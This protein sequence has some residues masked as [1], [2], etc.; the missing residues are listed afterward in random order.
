MRHFRI[1][2][3]LIM[4]CLALA[5]CGGGGGGG[6][7]VE[8]RVVDGYVAG[9][10]VYLVPVGE[11]TPANAIRHSRPTDNSGQ[12]KIKMP[13]KVF[14]NDYASYHLIAV[15]GTDT[16]TSTAAPTYTSPINSTV[17]TPLTTLLDQLAVGISSNSQSG[18]TSSAVAQAA[19]QIATVA[20][21]DQSSALNTIL[22]TDY[23]D[24]A[25][26]DANAQKALTM[27]FIIAELSAQGVIDG[28]FEGTVSKL[29]TAL[30]RT[31]PPTTINDLMIAAAGSD[32]TTQAKALVLAE[33]VM[34]TMNEAVVA[35]ASTSSS[36]GMMTSLQYN[37]HK[38]LGSMIAQVTP[39][40]AYSY[41]VSI[42]GASALVVDKSGT[43][44]DVTSSTV[45]QYMIDSVSSGPV[46]ALLDVDFSPLAQVVSVPAAA[47][48]R[49]GASVVRKAQATGVCANKTNGT[50]V[51]LACDLVLPGSFCTGTPGLHA[52]ATC[53]NGTAT[54][55]L[56]VTLSDYA[57]PGLPG[58]PKLNGTLQI[59]ANSMTLTNITNGSTSY[60]GSIS[61]AVDSTTSAMS[62]T[63]NDNLTIKSPQW[64]TLSLD[65]ITHGTI[66]PT[67][68]LSGVN[69]MKIYLSGSGTTNSSTVPLTLGLDYQR[70]QDAT[71]GSD[72]TDNVIVTLNGTLSNGGILRFCNFQVNEQRFFGSQTDQ[73]P[74]YMLVSFEPKSQLKTST[75][76]YAYF[77]GSGLRYNYAS[78]I[79]QYV[80][81]SGT[82]S[83][84]TTAP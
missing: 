57:F 80:S 30:K 54:L 36:A 73:N 6:T 23:L 82:F 7:T 10:T 47:A 12:F 70:Q 66:T 65:N 41:I 31:S 78:P 59:A 64:K 48:P 13:N 45:K 43:P 17:V 77:N 83:L 2:A 44:A 39:S 14:Q 11:T 69:D 21:I 46:Q 84:S 26:S 29:V 67:A 55:P 19:A 33:S 22:N 35:T 25:A 79:Y 4:G 51:D 68:D 42:T 3:L 34:R 5:G 52:T 50:T 60:N 81:G 71:I 28:S 16:A 32:T 56:S 15:G 40:N 53:E 20:G 62:F 61:Y 8:G 74:Q 9:A 18:L 76:G 38:S 27:S 72:L 63:V 75:N 58:S 37:L 24:K 49:Q 1:V